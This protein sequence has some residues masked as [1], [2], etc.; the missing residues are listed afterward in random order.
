[1]TNNNRTIVDA[2]TV[3]DQFDPGPSLEM[4]SNADSRSVQKTV[5]DNGVRIVTE[6]IPGARSV[7]SG[8]VFECG[9]RDEMRSE[10]GLAHFC[11]HLM[12][13]GTS[14]RS[15][16]EI[17]RLIDSAGGRVGGFTTRD[18]T[19]Y[20]ASVLG[21]Y[22]YHALDLL[23]DILLNST[24]PETHL[25]RERGAVLCELEGRMDSPAERAQ[26]LLKRNAWPNHALGRNL[27]GEVDTVSRF[28]RE[29][30]IY[31]VHGNYTPNRMIIA[32][33]GQL[34]HDD[35]VAQARDVFWRLLG[36]SQ[37]RPVSAPSPTPTLATELSGTNQSYF[38][39]GVPAPSY[40]HASRYVLHLVNEIIAG[41]VS[42]RLF[43]R[44]REDNG[45]VYEVHSDYHAYRDGGMIVI[46]GSTTAENQYQVI[47]IILEEL[48]ALAV[49]EKPVDED[50]MCRA[51][52]RLRA[53]YLIAGEDIHTRMSRLATQEMYFGRHIPDSEMLDQIDT[54]DVDSVRRLV[55]GS[56]LEWLGQLCAALVGPSND[57]LQKQALS[58][59]VTAFRE[60]SLARSQ[61]V[62]DIDSVRQLSTTRGMGFGGYR[63][64]RSPAVPSVHV[65]SAR[66]RC[67]NGKHAL[68]QESG[69]MIRS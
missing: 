16:L 25:E 64:G 29:D 12:F 13:Q 20:F 36:E 54:I 43:C 8:I 21:D 48:L 33:T 59:L 1:M 11:E 9:P 50:E 17:G 35:F 22:C 23:G 63:P 3:G 62:V 5:L 4:I 67:A 53:S 24:F 30:V 27:A 55:T 38:C 18:Y 41:G 34:I 31:F 65:D 40:A 28:T 47:Q 14:N 37:P 42:S 10:S 19:C 66:E 6:A 15:S 2:L 26:D 68:Y 39:L 32:A 49:W 60:K 46:E 58:D 44:L 61:C 45:L 56:L 69:E 51:K 52:T 7:S 57:E